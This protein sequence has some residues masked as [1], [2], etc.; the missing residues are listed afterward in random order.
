VFLFSFPDGKPALRSV[1]FRNAGHYPFFLFPPVNR[2]QLRDYVENCMS[3]ESRRLSY[4][5]FSE[6][7][8]KMSARLA[9]SR[10]FFACVNK[11]CLNSCH[12]ELLLRRDPNIGNDSSVNREEDEQPSRNVPIFVKRL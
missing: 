3:I 6:T 11:R 1:K 4:A 7:L 5:S 12:G 9:A 8:G 2:R 10:E